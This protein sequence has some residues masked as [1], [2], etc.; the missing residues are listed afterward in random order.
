MGAHDDLCEPGH[1]IWPLRLA[2]CQRWGE[3]GRSP[4]FRTF[5]HWPRQ[6][7]G[8]VGP[9]ELRG[10]ES[11][12][13]GAERGAHPGCGERGEYAPPGERNRRC[14]GPAPI[15]PA[16]KPKSYAPCRSTHPTSGSKSLS[17]L[18]LGFKGGAPEFWK[19]FREILRM[20]VTTSAVR[21]PSAPYGHM[22]SRGRASPSS[23]ARTCR[24]L[25]QAA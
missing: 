19:V 4:G 24:R 12:S 13:S 17:G 21:C 22:G 18:T 2:K 7:Q 16:P 3:D 5:C 23:R 20:G 25:R 14:S 1:G 8:L 6:D 15:V 9:A 11:G 10:R